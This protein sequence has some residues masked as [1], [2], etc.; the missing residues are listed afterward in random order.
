MSKYI[1]LLSVTILLLVAGNQWR[2]DENG[3]VKFGLDQ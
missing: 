3:S 2:Y 1:A